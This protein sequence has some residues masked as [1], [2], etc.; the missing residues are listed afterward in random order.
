MF[1]M[2]FPGG[3]Y[4]Q[5][6]SANALINSLFLIAANWGGGWAVD[7]FGYR[8]IFIWDF[9]FTCL[10]TLLLALVWARFLRLGGDRGFRSPLDDQPQPDT[11][12]PSATP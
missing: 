12:K 9:L 4:G 11:T 2:L 1:A 8:F 5:F 7:R 3:R 10:A 6:S